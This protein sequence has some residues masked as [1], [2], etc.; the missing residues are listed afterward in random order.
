MLRLDHDAGGEAVARRL[1]LE[2]FGLQQDRVEQ[3]V[4]ALAGLAPTRARTCSS[5]PHS[6][7]MTSCL[8]EL[9]AHAIRVGIGLVDLVDRDDDR[10][11]R[12]ACA[13]WIASTVCGMTPSS[14]ATTS[15]TMSVTLRAAGAH[16]GERRVARRIEERD[17]A[18]RR[19]HVVR[20]DVLRDAARLARRDLGAADV[21]EQRGLAVVDVAHDRDDRRTRRL[22]LGASASPCRSSSIWSSLSTLACGPSPRP[23]A[24]RCPDRSAG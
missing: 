18:L 11:V 22:G 1:E 20:A 21:V 3:L 16:R 23:R 14:A 10:H 24:P 2:H 17:H 9:G 15:T 4:D 6:S 19:F 13:C 8:D 12:R 5:P 7:G